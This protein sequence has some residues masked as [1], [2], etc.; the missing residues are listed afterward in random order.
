MEEP[1]LE[2]AINQGGFAVVAC[3]ALYM[4]NAVWKQYTKDLRESRDEFKEL[5][6]ENTKALATFLSALAEFRVTLN[7][8]MNLLK[9]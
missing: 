1:I 9:K 7:E 8:L 6:K 3:L 2:T 5:L 4:L